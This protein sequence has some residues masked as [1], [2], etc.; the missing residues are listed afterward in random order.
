M[1]L[2]ILLK[3]NLIL[4]LCIYFLKSH[5]DTARSQ[6][7]FNLQAGSVLDGFA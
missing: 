6:I 5:R 2:T 7:M 4:D 3:P 1:Y